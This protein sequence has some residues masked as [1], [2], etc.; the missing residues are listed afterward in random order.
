MNLTVT[1]RNIEITEAIKN[2]LSSKINKALQG[3][4]QSAD[5]HVILY[6]KKH[7]HIANVTVKV[8]RYTAYAKEETKNLYITL[9]SVL[10]KIKKQL[11]K[12]NAR[13]QNHKT[14]L[15]IL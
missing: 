14:K 5:C 9:D 7:R 1:S 15:T 6:V 11:K 12:H 13:S 8:K 4:N 2:Y 3:T 10:E